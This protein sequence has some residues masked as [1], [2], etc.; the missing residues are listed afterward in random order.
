[1]SMKGKEQVKRESNFSLL[2]S[3]KGDRVYGFFDQVAVQVCFGIAAWY[4]LCGSQ[5]GLYLPASEAIP[6]ILVGN[7]VPLFLIGFIG[8]YSSRFGMDSITASE[9]AFGAKG[10]A[11]IIVMF[12]VQLVVSAA[13][14]MLLFGQ[15]AIK[16]SERIGLPGFLCSEFPG[17]SIWSLLALGFG[18]FIAYSGPTAMMWFSRFSAVFMMLVI[19]W[20]I[21]YLFTEYGFNFIYNA[22]PQGRI[23]VEGNQELTTRWNRAA[24]LETNLG[25]GFSWAFMFG[26]F[27]RLG[28]SE[29]QAYHGCIW[30]WGI[31][32]CLAI[33]FGAYVA[34][35]TG[36]YDPSDWIIEAS[37]QSNMVWLAVLGL[38]FMAIANISSIAINTYPGAIAI[39]ARWPKIT[40]L[41]AVLCVGLPTLILLNPEIFYKISNIY[42]IVGLLTSLFGGVMIA[43][44][45]FISK[46]RVSLRE[47][48]NRKKGF[49][50]YK[51][52]N[53][54]GFI[55]LGVGWI[56]YLLILNPLTYTSLTGL[57]PY[58]CASLP[59]FF[60]TG[61]TYIILM[62]VWIL[63]KYPVTFVNNIK[64]KGIL[65]NEHA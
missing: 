48:Y 2:P 30:G 33:V 51:G 13:M 11:L 43:D 64:R 41:I 19:G 63:K 23:I 22:E 62:K 61:V 56:T 55:A 39:T 31:V 24:A 18:I 52:I 9:G 26:M 17:V 37:E 58:T 40:W 60:V 50:F 45:L 16:F 14:P 35:A 38:I 7:C 20:L 10:P 29:G 32:S 44:I 4:F 34:I 65:E 59:T 3:R 36:L 25:M 54:A 8:L 1:M 42:S 6:T 53:P 47:Y 28:K 49:H 46:G 5:T 12:V 57:F 27:T 21:Y 15:L